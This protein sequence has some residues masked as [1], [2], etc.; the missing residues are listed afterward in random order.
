[1][2]KTPKKSEKKEKRDRRRQVK[3]MTTKISKDDMQPFRQFL[4]H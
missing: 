4:N 2:F 1:M 3:W